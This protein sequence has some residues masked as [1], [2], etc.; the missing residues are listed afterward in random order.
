MIMRVPACLAFSVVCHSIVEAMRVFSLIVDG[1]MVDG[2]VYLGR[3]KMCAARTLGRWHLH[4]MG[5]GIGYGPRGRT[6]IVTIW[7]LG[8]G[9]RHAVAAAVGHGLI[10]G[11]SSIGCEIVVPSVHG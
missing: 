7:W 10:D 5:G 9:G 11:G 3:R 2:S 6:G 1:A 4:S 8:V